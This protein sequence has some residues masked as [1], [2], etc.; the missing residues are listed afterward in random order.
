MKKRII[1][2]ILSVCLCASL[3]AAW[4]LSS[5]AESIT[6]KDIATLRT[7]INGFVS[8]AEE[9][10]AKDDYQNMPAG[11]QTK[12][13]A[14]VKLESFIEEGKS[15]IKTDSVED[16][17]AFL[18]KVYGGWDDVKKEYTEPD[19]TYIEFLNAL[20][21][22]T[23]AIDEEVARGEK[24]YTKL[25]RKDYTIES[26]RELAAAAAALAAVSEGSNPAILRLTRSEAWKLLTAYYNAYDNLVPFDG[27]KEINDLRGMLYLNIMTNETVDIISLTRRSPF[28]W[29]LPDLFAS[30]QENPN[31]PETLAF[32]EWVNGAIAAYNNPNVTAE[33]LRKYV[34]DKYYLKGENNLDIDT[35]EE[36]YPVESPDELN[37]EDFHAKYGEKA[38]RVMNPLATRD[39][40]ILKFRNSL[41]VGAAFKN[42]VKKITD[43]VSYDNDLGYYNSADYNEFS[44]IVGLYNEMANDYLTS[45][46]E[47]REGYEEIVA[48]RDELLTKKLDINLYDV[49]YNKVMKFYNE[50]IKN[51]RDLFERE[52]VL[53]LETAIAKFEAAKA[54]YENYVNAGGT[55]ADKLDSLYQ[56]LITATYFLQQ[57]RSEIRVRENGD[58]P[59]QGGGSGSTDLKNI[60]LDGVYNAAKTLLT[61]MTEFNNYMEDAL[62]DDGAY[63]Y[64]EESLALFREK[65]EALQALVDKYE[66]EADA[67]QPHTMVKSDFITLML[68]AIKVQIDMENVRTSND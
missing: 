40:E 49:V 63:P 5:S 52:T 33:E 31:A 35:N 43:T 4:T 57:T 34:D 23:K 14:T 12:A 1:A 50:S 46:K 53:R 67:E 55:D 2:A 15:L 11:M 66:E 60:T 19:K 3:V 20:F 44:Q 36:S 27:D 58:D 51:Y 42:A 22:R 10:A 13:E 65:L 61:D 8:K 28:G 48:A 26:W 47:L 39:N 30:S 56:N 37:D 45:D 17:E 62:L 9:L 21:L 18:L 64:T 16:A 38:G 59:N 54:E 6:G 25:S 24:G 68:E 7:E 29:E 41:F 32:K